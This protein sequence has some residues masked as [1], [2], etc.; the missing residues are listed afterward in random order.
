MRQ[1][2]PVKDLP[3]FPVTGG[4]ILLAIGVTLAWWSKAVDMS[5]LMED[6]GIRRGELWRLLTS[7]LLHANFLHLAFNLYWTWV[8]GTLIEGV[9]GHLRTLGIFVL[10]AMVSNGGEFAL[11][12]GG[13]GLSGVG[14][15]LFGL[16]WVLSKRDARFTDAVDSQTVQLFVVWFLICVVST[17]L[18]WMAIA[19]IAHGLGCVAGALL[20]WTI[21]VPLP[22][23][24]AGV[25]SMLLLMIAVLLGDT[26]GRPWVNLSKYAGG[27]YAKEAGNDEARLGY[28][29]LE[30]NQNGTAIRWFRDAVRMDPRDDT[31]WY[32]LGRM[33]GRRRSRLP[34]PRI[35]KPA[36]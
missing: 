20:G 16:T 30:A 33:I 6:V 3:K 21:S 22:K 34:S 14:Y 10:L 11:L 17:V 15:G 12:S 9:F 19:N 29:A 4:T 18:H 2:P 13:V 31:S 26:V 1:P 7:V 35:R 23:R 8:F 27:D 32:D 28:A 24:M 5:P 25:A 36:I